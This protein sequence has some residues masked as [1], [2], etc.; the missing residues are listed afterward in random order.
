[1]SDYYELLGV[2]P[3]AS[4]A[5]VRQAYLSAARRWHPDRFSEASAS[6][7]LDAEAAMRRVNEA[8]QHLG[9]D[10][11][12]Q[13]YDATLSAST[14]RTNG[15]ATSSGPVRV[16]VDGVPR[17]D[18]RLLD[19]DYVA[20]RM[21]ANEVT[22]SNGRSAAMKFLPWLGLLGVL[23]AIFVFSA[24]AG[25][26]SELDG[27]VAPVRVPAGECV[28]VMTESQLLTVSC[29]GP[30]DGQVIGARLPDGVCP[31]GTV[32]QEPT[33]DGVFLCLG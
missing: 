11:S 5:E 6:E 9:D 22:I 23:A 16:G 30:N 7:Q 20:T 2:E 18:P 3:T 8:W 29:D 28:R 10:G 32:R 13:R 21:A 33:P 1:M 17:I 26:D 27:G 31:S 12:R 24:Y 14:P 25:G 19:R 4:R 15:V